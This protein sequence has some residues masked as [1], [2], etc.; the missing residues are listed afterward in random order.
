MGRA[1]A[2]PAATGAYSAVPIAMPTGA[3]CA[4]TGS[5]I[6]RARTNHDHEAGADYQVTIPGQNCPTQEG[7]PMLPL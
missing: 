5:G 7:W 2:T 6:E 3:A 4:N 1:C